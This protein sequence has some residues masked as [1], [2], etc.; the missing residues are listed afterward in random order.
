[1]A[2]LKSKKLQT[3]IDG[4]GYLV[5]AGYTEPKSPANRAQAAAQYSAFHAALGDAAKNDSYLAH[6]QKAA[7][8]E[9]ATLLV[10]EHRECCD[11]HANCQCRIARSIRLLNP[12]L[13]A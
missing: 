7:M 13:E 8:R 1:M 4:D 2:A 12:F 9:V 10:A 3:A 5:P 6:E 11:G